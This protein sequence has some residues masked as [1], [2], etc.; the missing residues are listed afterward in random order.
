MSDSKLTLDWKPSTSTGPGQLSGSRALEAVCG[1]WLLLVFQTYYSE[2]PEF[3]FQL[4]VTKPGDTMNS[5]MRVP[6]TE[7]HSEWRA[8]PLDGY[9]QALMWS[10]E[11]AQEAAERLLFQYY[12]VSLGAGAPS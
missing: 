7:L 6:M 4:L 11:Q 2:Q 3:R 10:A 12:G 8:R 1:P 5:K 9:N